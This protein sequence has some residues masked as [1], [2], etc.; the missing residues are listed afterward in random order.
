MAVERDSLADRETDCLAN[1][2]L[3][4]VLAAAGPARCAGALFHDDGI[5]G[6]IE[7]TLCRRNTLRFLKRDH[8]CVE[9]VGNLSHGGIVGVGS[10]LTPVAVPLGKKFEIPARQ[11]ERPDVRDCELR[12][13]RGLLGSCAS[14]ERKERSGDEEEALVHRAL[15]AATPNA[16]NQFVGRNNG[17]G[18]SL[19]SREPGGETR[20]NKNARA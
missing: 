17:S 9:A 8:V 4:L 19:V 15:L 7:H 16:F 5:A 18:G 10:R 20:Q 3:R 6:G 2:G 11:H 12:M 13:L 14:A 1:D